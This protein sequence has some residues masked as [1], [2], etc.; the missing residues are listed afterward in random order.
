M[1]LSHVTQVTVGPMEDLRK[2]VISIKMLL[3]RKLDFRMK[4]F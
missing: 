4:Y 3:S 2:K 1:L